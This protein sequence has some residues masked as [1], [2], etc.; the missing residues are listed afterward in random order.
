MLERRRAVALESL[1][2]FV[3]RPLALH[4]EHANRLPF[5]SQRDVHAGR[6]GLVVGVHHDWDAKEQVAARQ[7]HLG[8][9]VVVH[10]LHTHNPCVTDSSEAW[11]LVERPQLRPSRVSVE[12]G[13][14]SFMKPV[15]GEKPPTARSS[16]SHALRSLHAIVRPSHEAS[17][18]SRLAASAMRF[19]TVPPCGSMSPSAPLHHAH[20]E[21]VT[22]SLN[23][24]Y[25]G[26]TVCVTSTCTVWKSPPTYP[27]L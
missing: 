2:R 11:R 15:R 7:P 19:T 22:V 1:D 12:G 4:L 18:W 27:C 9:T 14:T 24:L 20:S 25:W 17:S 10:V 16:T 3:R 6:E 8:N 13:G 21:A 5:I 23:G 26:V